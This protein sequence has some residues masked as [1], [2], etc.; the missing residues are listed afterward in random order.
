AL[1]RKCGSPPRAWGRRFHV[2]GAHWLWRFTPT[3]VGTAAALASASTIVSVHPHVRGDGFGDG[4]AFAPGIGSPPR[5]WG[6][7]VKLAV[8]R[9][10]D[11]FTPTCV[12]TA[13]FLQ[14]VV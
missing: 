13:L 5:A 7:P 3:C 6:R 2:G 11:R 12:G 8:G 10:G 9:L 14:S 4:T 1:C